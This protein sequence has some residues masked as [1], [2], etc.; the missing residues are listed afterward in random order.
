[1]LSQGGYMLN[2]PSAPTLALLTAAT[3]FQLMRI[4]YEEDMLGRNG[5]YSA[6]AEGVSYRLL[7]GVW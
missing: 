4:R 3:G 7:P 2:N 6:C 1:M 5:T